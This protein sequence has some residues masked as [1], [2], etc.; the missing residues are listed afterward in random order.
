MHTTA[1]TTPRTDRPQDRALALSLGACKH[2]DAYELA[3]STPYHVICGV[4]QYAFLLATF[5][6]PHD[7]IAYARGAAASGDYWPGTIIS[8]PAIGYQKTTQ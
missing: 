2:T 7:A 3:A 4:N 5:Q 1:D 6:A 8:I